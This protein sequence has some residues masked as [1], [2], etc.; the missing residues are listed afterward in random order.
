M[1][2]IVQTSVLHGHMHD[3][4]AIALPMYFAET[5][6]SAGHSLTPVFCRDCVEP[7]T[8]GVVGRQLLTTVPYLSFE[9]CYSVVQWRIQD[10][11][12]GGAV[13]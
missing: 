1:S 11:I 4:L 13:S 9:S 8:F 6:R 7:K 5:A 3:L 10:W 2:S 12:K